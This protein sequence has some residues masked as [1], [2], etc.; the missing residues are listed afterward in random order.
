MM[1][2]ACI[3][4]W[5]SVMAKHLI[6]RNAASKVALPKSRRFLLISVYE[7]VTIS[8][9]SWHSIREIPYST[10]K[11]W[12]YVMHLF[13]TSTHGV[14]AKELQCQLGMPYKYVRRMAMQS[15]ST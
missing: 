12:F 7:V 8:T 15:E 11:S 5:K 3:I 6:A 4:W 14:P 1:I 2:P 13:T 9:L 10:Y